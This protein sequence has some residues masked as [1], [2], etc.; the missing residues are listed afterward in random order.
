MALLFLC[1]S[2]GIDGA[3]GAMAIDRLM[4][5]KMSRGVLDSSA[6]L[7]LLLS[8]RHPDEVPVPVCHAKHGGVGETLG[9]KVGHAT[10]ATSHRKRDLAEQRG[11]LSLLA[12][13]SAAQKC[14]K[15]QS[16]WPG[17]TKPKNGK[18]SLYLKYQ[19]P[20]IKYQEVIL[21]TWPLAYGTFLP[22]I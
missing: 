19:V 7:G 14:A 2:C 5:T 4:E 3:L 6:L 9:R 17:G 13:R 15:M 12:D 22:V 18:H 1:F 8:P 10:R 16:A 11:C 20:S 21:G